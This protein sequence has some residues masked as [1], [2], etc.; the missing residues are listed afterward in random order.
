MRGGIAE[1][2]V[3]NMDG[4]GLL[5]STAV[6]SLDA[7]GPCPSFALGEGIETLTVTPT[8]TEPILYFIQHV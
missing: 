5:A 4:R 7:G 1:E 8:P 6:A 3:G 2:R